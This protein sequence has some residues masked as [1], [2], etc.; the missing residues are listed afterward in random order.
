MN[1]EDKQLS[2]E[3]VQFNRHFNVS[4]SAYFFNTWL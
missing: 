2:L 4:L 1:Y 3:P